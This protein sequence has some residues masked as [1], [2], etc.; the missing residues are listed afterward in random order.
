MRSHL[1]STETWTQ[2]VC[3]SDSSGAGTGV[4]D[5]EKT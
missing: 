2:I 3:D 5:V 4:S 1:I